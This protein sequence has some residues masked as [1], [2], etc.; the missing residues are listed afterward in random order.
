MDNVPQRV[1]FITHLL[2]HGVKV[3]AWVNLFA[4]WGWQDGI[5]VRALPSHS[6]CSIREGP[7]QKGKS[8]AEAEASATR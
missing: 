5:F 4:H 8:I 6:R 1:A 3:A 2:P 7:G